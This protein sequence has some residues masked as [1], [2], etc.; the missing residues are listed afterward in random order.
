MES[1]IGH[2]NPVQLHNIRERQ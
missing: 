2:L 1:I